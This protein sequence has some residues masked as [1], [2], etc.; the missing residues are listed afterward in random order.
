[1]RLTPLRACA[2]LRASA[3]FAR[4]I[5]VITTLLAVGLGMVVGAGLGLLFSIQTPGQPLPQCLA[6]GTVIGAV[7]FW[8]LHAL[9]KFVVR[10]LV[11][12]GLGVLVGTGLGL[13][14]LKLWPACPVP[15]LPLW[16]ALGFATLFLLRT[17]L[18]RDSE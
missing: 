1:M 13:A 5:F 6:F 14:V 2:G 9:L 4:M 8:L 18:K 10:S 17:W 12:L 11:W 7:L 15:Q 16:L 3:T